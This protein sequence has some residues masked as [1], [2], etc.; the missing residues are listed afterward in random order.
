M[1]RER[2]VQG[3]FRRAPD[4]GEHVSHACRQ[5][6]NG[7]MPPTGGEQEIRAETA[8]SKAVKRTSWFALVL[9]RLPIVVAVATGF[10]KH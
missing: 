1:F 7:R 4:S 10:P 2:G 6:E 5:E 3:M 9:G 8:G